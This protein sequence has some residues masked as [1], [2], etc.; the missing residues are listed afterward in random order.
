MQAVGRLESVVHVNVCVSPSIISTA[1]L[2]P[3]GVIVTVVLV[4]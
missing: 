2:L 1:L 3:A 4:L